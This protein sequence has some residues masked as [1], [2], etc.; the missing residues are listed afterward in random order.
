MTG[1]RRFPLRN[2]IRPDTY[3]YCVEAQAFEPIW[4][5]L[6]GC[7]GEPRQFGSLD[8]YE[9]NAPSF[10]LRASLGTGSVTVIK[11]RGLNEVDLNKFHQ[12]M[13]FDEEQNVES[14]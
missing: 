3:R 5:E 2:C 14:A 6:V 13:G 1:T 7:F 4:Q 9:I 12:I 11:K 8:L 10:L